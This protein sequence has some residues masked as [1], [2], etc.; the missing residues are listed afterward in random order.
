MAELKLFNNPLTG[1]PALVRL[2]LCELLHDLRQGN[3]GR[4]LCESFVQM[5]VR[6]PWDGLD[7]DPLDATDRYF[8][9]PE[10]QRNYNTVIWLLLKKNGLLGNMRRILVPDLDKGDDAYGDIV[11]KSYGRDLIS[12]FLLVDPDPKWVHTKDCFGMRG[13]MREDLAA[14]YITNK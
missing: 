4:Y 6:N 9:N 12:S 3:R 2:W 10:N 11:L 7:L 5:G 8:N 13:L 14:E 1:A